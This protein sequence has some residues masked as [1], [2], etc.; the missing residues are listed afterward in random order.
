MGGLN[1]IKHMRSNEYTCYCAVC[2]TAHTYSQLKLARIYILPGRAKSVS[3]TGCRR[4]HILSVDSV[5]PHYT[6]D[7]YFADFAVVQFALVSTAVP[8]SVGVSVDGSPDWII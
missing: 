2:R 7:Q 4:L 5:E 1:Y 6:P 8:K 3:C